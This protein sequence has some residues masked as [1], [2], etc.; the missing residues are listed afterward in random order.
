MP[1]RLVPE[2]LD[3]VDMVAPIGKQLAMIDPKM[4]EVGDVEHIIATI[5][6]GVDN[7]V[8]LDF[9][10]DYGDERVGFCVTDSDGEHF[11]A[12]LEQAEDRHLACRPSAAFAFSDAAEIAFIDLNL[13]RQFACLFEQFIVNNLAQTMI[14]IRR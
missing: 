13:A 1:F 2:V 6:I 7:A 4:V 3:A 5:A 10:G 8:W 12:A 11:A 9:T 14:E